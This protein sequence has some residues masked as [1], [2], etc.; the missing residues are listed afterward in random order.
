MRDGPTD[1]L[2][3]SNA[4]VVPARPALMRAMNERLMLAQVRTAGPVSRTDLARMSGLS[5]PTVT[6]ALGNLERDGLVRVAGLRT[7]LRGPA[8]VLYEVRPE[9]GYVLGLDVG[10]EYLRAALADLS[11]AVRARA[12]RRVHAASAPGRVS[13][14]ISLADEMATTAGIRRSRFSQVVVGSPGVYEPERGALVAARNLPGWERPGVVHELRAVFGKSTALEN[15][16]DL[17]ALAE[18]DHGHGKEFATFCFVSVGTGIGMG[19]VIDG[20]LRRGAHGAAGEIAYLPIG[21]EDV[22]LSEIRKRGQLEAV[23]SAA[24]VVRAARR[25]GMSGSLTARRVFAAAADGDARAVAAV[26]AE[27][28]LVA[29]AVGSVVAVVDP[30][31]IVL[32]GGIGRAPGFAA[33]VAAALVPFVPFVPEIRVSAL[34][35]DGVVDGCLAAGLEM[36]WERLLER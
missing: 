33:A 12:S 21:N 7:G 16:V 27:A 23:A 30:E 36:A 15:D 25:M 9:A 24:A 32:G 1:E 19:L 28:E 2:T 26:A 35:D 10:R 34:G 29:R 22:P 31:L 20:R 17:A 5:K 6:V 14:M 13:E 18:R 4:R 11:G 3:G 8:A